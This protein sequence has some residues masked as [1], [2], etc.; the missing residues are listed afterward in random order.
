M[1]R[2][3]VTSATHAAPLCGRLARVAYPMAKCLVATPCVATPALAAATIDYL[4]HYH[5]TRDFP[6]VFSKTY[7]PDRPRRGA[8]SGCAECGR[9]RAYAVGVLA[10]L[11]TCASANAAGTSVAECGYD[12][13]DACSPA[14]GAWLPRVPQSA[15]SEGTRPSTTSV[16]DE[17]IDP[18]GV[19]GPAFLG[20]R[21][22][23]SGTDFVYGK[24]GPPKGSA[25]Y[26]PVHRIA[27]Y[28][29]GCC[30]WH[31]VVLASNVDAP[32]KH[33]ATR[34]L[35]GLRTRRGIA[36]GDS[37]ER[38]RAT[39]GPAPLRPAPRRIEEATLAY[40]RVIRFPKPYS[41]CE[42]ANTF[43]FQHGRLIAMDFTDAC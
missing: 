35:T 42:E 2:T 15:M 11:L 21:S 36:L 14:M 4:S 13:G 34:I 40:I 27:Y 18:A 5:R 25:V 33:V 12:Y 9:M 17:I 22:V 1:A 23:F 8:C 30:A 19:G 39:Y 32:P 10:L 41:P 29:E 28:A 38:V 37:P 7:A 26:D 20:Q 3:A 6:Q 16:H 43:L 24:A 31:H